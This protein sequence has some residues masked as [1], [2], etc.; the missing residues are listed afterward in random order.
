MLCHGGSLQ[1]SCPFLKHPT[2]SG[3]G[4]S[5]QWQE[6]QE[7]LEKAIFLASLISYH[8]IA[9]PLLLPLRGY[10]ASGL[11]DVLVL[12]AGSQG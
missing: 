3:G 6:Y 10:A 9:R 2:A 1:V 5:V 11:V 8:I 12:K 7:V 4:R